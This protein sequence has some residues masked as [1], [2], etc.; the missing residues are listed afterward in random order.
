MQ[1]D[2]HTLVAP[3]IVALFQDHAFLHIKTWK[4]VARTQRKLPVALSK[5]LPRCTQGTAPAT[6]AAAPA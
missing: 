1:N 6:F 5:V 3:H 4:G 2:A